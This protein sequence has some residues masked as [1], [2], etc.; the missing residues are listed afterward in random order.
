MMMDGYDR[1][2]KFEVDKMIIRL[3]TKDRG[4]ES[5]GSE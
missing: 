2:L 1:S 3:A 4:K 5:E